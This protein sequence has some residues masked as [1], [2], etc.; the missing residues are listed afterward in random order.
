MPTILLHILTGGWVMFLVDQLILSQP[1]GHIMPTTLLRILTYSSLVQT[2]PTLHSITHRMWTL[3]TY[4]LKKTLL[5][6]L[7][8]L[9]LCMLSSYTYLS[10][11]LKACVYVLC[12]YRMHWSLLLKVTFFPKVHIDLLYPQIISLNLKFLNFVIFK[13][14][15]ACQAWICWP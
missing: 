7:N 5:T 14:A 13:A 12:T 11:L 4:H 10:Y 3:S 1:G 9:G 8:T 6:I 15:L 2:L